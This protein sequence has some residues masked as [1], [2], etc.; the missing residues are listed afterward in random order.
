L[1]EAHFFQLLLFNVRKYILR[2][3]LIF[4][5]SHPVMLMV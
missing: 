3:F 1:L 4:S 5:N 2:S